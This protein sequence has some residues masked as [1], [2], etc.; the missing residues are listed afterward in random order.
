MKTLLAVGD[1][2]GLSVNTISKNKEAFTKSVS[3]S[4]LRQISVI[5]DTCVKNQFK[6]TI[7][8][9][10]YPANKSHAA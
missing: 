9:F 5:G 6:I 4:F 10:R 3:T 1:Y 7:A 2:F 8:K